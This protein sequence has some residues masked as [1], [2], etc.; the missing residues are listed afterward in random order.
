[1]ATGPIR[2]V[3]VVDD[4]RMVVEALRRALRPH[5]VRVAS[6]GRQALEQLATESFDLI[7]CDLMM[8]DLTGMDVYDALRAQHPGAEQ[9]MVFMSG[10]TFTQRAS[11]FLATVPNPLLDK[12]FDLAAVRQL[13]QACSDDAALPRRAS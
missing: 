10:G 6:S 7:F 8:P 3:L 12:P 9:R 11:E 2:R 5:D 13:V 1:M 4:E